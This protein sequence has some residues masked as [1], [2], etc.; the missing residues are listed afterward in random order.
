MPDYSKGKVYKIVSDACDEVY[1]GSTVQRL[2]ERFRGHHTN[3]ALYLDGKSNYVTSFKI[4]EHGHCH[5]ILLEDVPCERKEQLYARERYW[6]E[7]VD[8]INKQLPGR[9]YKEWYQANREA[10][11][12]QKKVHYQENRETVMDRVKVYYQE[13]RG[14]ILERREK[15]YECS[16]GSSVR[17]LN[18]ARHL[19]T[20]KHQ[21]FIAN[22]ESI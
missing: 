7:K 5:I 8:C 20:K 19:K 3:Y 14:E 4:L 18:K 13:N 17:I 9:T 16:C 12:E 6:I 10:I 22:S 11:S 1:V 15:K 21:A 2:A